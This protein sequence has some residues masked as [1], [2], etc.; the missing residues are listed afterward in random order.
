MVHW[1]GSG[2]SLR[3]ARTTV[4]RNKVSFRC[5][6]S[7]GSYLRFATA[8]NRTSGRERPFLAIA[9]ITEERDFTAFGY[10]T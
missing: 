2:H 4:V 10:P 9:R 5:V 8:A 3:S 7:N 6:C 1:A